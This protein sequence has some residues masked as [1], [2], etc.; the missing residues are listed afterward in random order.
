MEAR[1]LSPRAASAPFHPMSR[2]ASLART[3]AAHAAHT[4]IRE[5]PIVV[6]SFSPALF[7]R[8][9]GCLYLLEF[10]SLDSSFVF[11]GPAAAAAACTHG[12]VHPLS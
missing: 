8:R 5:I 7:G 10:L 2:R 6:V 11:C 3:P 12:V 9:V 1:S 4:H